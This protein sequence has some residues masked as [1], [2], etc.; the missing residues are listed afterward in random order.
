MDGEEVMLNNCNLQPGAET[1]Y[2]TDDT[3]LV[4]SDKVH[5]LNLAS[6][7]EMCDCLDTHTT[8][9]LAYFNIILIF[10]CL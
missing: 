9:I 5:F 4:M 8:M 1:V 7:P 10:I 3:N 2:G 6:Y